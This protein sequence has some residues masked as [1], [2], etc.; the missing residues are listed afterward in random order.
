MD[1]NKEK[2]HAI[3]AQIARGAIDIGKINKSDLLSYNKKIDD[4]AMSIYMYASQLHNEF[5][6][7]IHESVYSDTDSLHQ[8]EEGVNN[9]EAQDS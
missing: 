2:L 1:M 8:C 3:I 4:L 5:F 9:A 6:P 7:I